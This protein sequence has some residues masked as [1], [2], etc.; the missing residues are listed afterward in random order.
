MGFDYKW[1]I[2]GYEVAR[3]TAGEVVIGG[4]WGYFISYELGTFLAQC[5]NFPLQRNIMNSSLLLKAT[6]I[7]QMDRSGK[8]LPVIS[9]LEK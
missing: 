2:L 6:E 3:S 5:V 1:N 8:N 7:C 4:G 9:M